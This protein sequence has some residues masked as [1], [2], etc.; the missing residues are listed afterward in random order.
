MQGL[1]HD[2][3]ATATAT[4]TA[5]VTAQCPG[6]PALQV[7]PPTAFGGPG[8]ISSPEDLQVAAIASCFILSFKAI[9][10]ASKLEWSSI[11]VDAGGTLDQQDRAIQF[12]GFSLNVNLTLADASAADKA[13]RLL[14][15]AKQTC[16]IT[17][18]LRADTEM[19]ATVSG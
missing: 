16:F 12:T 14:G 11:S 5:H 6:Q 1:P 17:N 3:T 8:D 4:A 13:E 7:A 10:A 18:S 15:K 2:Y 19:S 9:A